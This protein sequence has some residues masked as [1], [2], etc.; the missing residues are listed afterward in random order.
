MDHSASKRPS[1]ELILKFMMA[2]NSLIN[3]KPVKPLEDDH[4]IDL[5]NEAI[6]QA[7]DATMR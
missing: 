5:E 7:S 1:M 3:T 6:S 2:L 4:D